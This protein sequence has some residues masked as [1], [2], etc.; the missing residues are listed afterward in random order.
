MTGVQ[1]CAL[2]IYVS[3]AVS[4]AEVNLH[5]DENQTDFETTVETAPGEA[6]EGDPKEE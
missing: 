3:A 1:T 4:E 6:S 2:P 5:T